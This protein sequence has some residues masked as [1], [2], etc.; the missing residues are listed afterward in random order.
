MVEGIQLL[1]SGLNTDDHPLV[2]P[3]GDSVF[4]QDIVYGQDGDFGSLVGI[5]AATEIPLLPAWSSWANKACIGSCEYIQNNS[6]IFFLYGETTV[7]QTTTKN[8]V[9]GEVLSDD[10]INVV[11]YLPPNMP[12]NYT[13][14]TR[15]YPYIIDKF[16][17]FTDGIVE[18]ILINIERA[19]LYQQNN[20][21]PYFVEDYGYSSGDKVYVKGYGLYTYKGVTEKIQSIPWSA[22]N[23][24]NFEKIGT[25]VNVFG[26]RYDLDTTPQLH[27]SV[28]FPSSDRYISVDVEKSISAINGLSRKLK[29]GVDP[30]RFAN[31]VSNGR[32]RMALVADSVTYLYTLDIEV[33]ADVTTSAQWVTKLHDLAVLIVNYIN[34]QT[35]NV[36]S[37]SIDTSTVGSEFIEI[38]DSYNGQLAAFVSNSNNVNPYIT[39]T[40]TAQGASPI[41]P[42]LQLIFQQ[43]LFTISSTGLLNKGWISTQFGFTTPLLPD[44]I[45]TTYSL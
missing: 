44:V 29:I 21:V 15:I 45:E 7:G 40:D 35:Y 9:I 17:G 5:K 8:V 1:G 18:P 3:N 2:R 26:N 13:K 12:V 41:A 6:F 33:G 39:S 31:F 16:L 25:S 34:A 30:S 14:D 24:L 43:P 32:I 36:L 10:S 4:R 38:Q 11:G 37:V 20:P 28:L 42:P 27:S 19:K 23:P 22:G